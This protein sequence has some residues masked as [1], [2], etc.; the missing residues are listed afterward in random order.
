MIRMLSNKKK[1]TLSINKQHEHY[2]LH[3]L[4]RAYCG[5]DLIEIL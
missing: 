1:G 3:G 2:E 4:V 5:F